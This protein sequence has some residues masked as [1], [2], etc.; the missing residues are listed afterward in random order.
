MLEPR[1]TP[2]VLRVPDAR[3]AFQANQMRPLSK[4]LMP[5]PHLPKSKGPR[6]P[7]YQNA[8]IQSEAEICTSKKSCR[9][10][11]DPAALILQT[12]FA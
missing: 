6:R 8:P 10:R 7:V 4:P 9:I 3:G 2:R 1:R 12:V 5:W 11:S